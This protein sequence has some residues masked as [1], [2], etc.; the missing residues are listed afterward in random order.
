MGNPP[1][2]KNSVSENVVPTKE[3]PPVLQNAAP[4]SPPPDGGVSAWVQCAAGFCI[5][6][7]T[8]GLLNT[9]GIF[10]AYYERNLLHDSSPSQISW[11]GTVQ[12][13][14]IMLGSVYSGPL[15]DWG[16]LRALIWT[17][18]FMLV[19]GMFMTSLCSLYWQI[20]LAQGFFMGLGLGCL[21]TPSVGVIATYFRKRLGLAMGIATSGSTIGG[22]VY[23][24][25]FHR[26]IEPVGFGWASR[27][28]AF[29]MIF[30][31]ILPVLGMRTRLKP[32]AVRRVFDAG[33]WKEPDFTLFGLA[34]FVS[35]IGMYIPFFY[36]QLYC[37]EKSV[38]TDGLNFYLLPI[39]NASG[40]FG[41]VIVGYIA[42]HIGSMN[43]YAICGGLCSVLL[44]GWIA[45][46]GEAGIIAFCVLYGFVVA[47][48]VTLA[49]TVVAAVLCPDMRQFGVRLTML[50]VPSAIGLLIGNPVAGAILK[51]GWV[52]LQ[53]FSA[54]TVIVGALLTVAARISKVGWGITRRC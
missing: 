27:T 5:F 38:I 25:M 1:E 15:Y 41:R 43:A 39:M 6:F 35:Y 45:I 2:S 20:L 13:S 9:F 28:I 12:S 3:L 44:F 37:F 49:P 16:Y 4:L 7:N 46:D 11:I 50:Q 26:L 52:G 32:P 36:I 33:A 31:S 54:A 29:V 10:Q 24:I 21:F 17:G 40:F 48:L 23:P 8:W 47:G 53:C 18:S 34:L 30:L 51:R 14:F 22:I 42:D 19:F